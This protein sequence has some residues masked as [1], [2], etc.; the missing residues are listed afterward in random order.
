MPAGTL[1]LR[2]SLVG[3]ALCHFEATGPFDVELVHKNAVVPRLLPIIG[4]L[5]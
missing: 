5:L 2:T 4:R 1:A 3:D